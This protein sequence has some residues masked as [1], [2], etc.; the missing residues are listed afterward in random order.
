MR[1]TVLA[2]T[3]PALLA[4]EVTFPEAYPPTNDVVM[5]NLVAVP[6]RDGVNLY[7]DVYRPKEP[8]KYPVIVSRTPYSSERAPSAYDSAVYFSRRG[9]VYIL[10]DVRGG[11]PDSR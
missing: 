11:C 4:A 1:W 6:M 2:L 7:A 10:Q 9:F 5:E 3:V 8:G